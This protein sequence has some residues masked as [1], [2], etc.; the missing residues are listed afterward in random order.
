MHVSF[1]AKT[2]AD[3]RFEEPGNYWVLGIG[4]VINGLYD[5]AVVSDSE[6]SSVYILTRDVL[7]F[8]QR[9]E[10]AILAFVES[11]GFTK[12]SNKPRKTLHR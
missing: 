12:E 9:Y 3:A 10:K 1:N 8:E 11:I 4:P 6:K 7:R 5:W 2:E